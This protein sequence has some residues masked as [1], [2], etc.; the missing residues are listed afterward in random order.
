MNV[1]ILHMQAWNNKQQQ[2]WKLTKFRGKIGILFYFI[3]LKEW[4][5]KDHIG[6][7]REFGQ[8]I[9]DYFIAN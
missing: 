3:F 5:Y 6:P 1:I 4:Y 2:M 9:D 8:F 7:E